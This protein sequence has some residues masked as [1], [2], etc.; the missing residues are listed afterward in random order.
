MVFNLFFPN[1]TIL[2]CFFF[3]FL[4]IDLYFLVPAVIVQIFDPT[5]GLVVSAGTHSNEANAEIQT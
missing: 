2:S 5:A 1:N 3:F 4:V